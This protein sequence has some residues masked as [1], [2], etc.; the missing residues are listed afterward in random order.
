MEN[1]RTFSSHLVCALRSQVHKHFFCYVWGLEKSRSFSSRPES[2]EER[3]PSGAL[4]T[5]A[6]MC[7]FIF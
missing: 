7:L 3:G 4:W 2:E 1:M 5:L 6:V